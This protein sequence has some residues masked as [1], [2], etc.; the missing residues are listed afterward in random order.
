[1]G[2]KEKIRQ[3]EERIKRKI[4]EIEDSVAYTKSEIEQFEYQKRE[5]SKNY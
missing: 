3:E 5:S 1:M 2:Y 4:K